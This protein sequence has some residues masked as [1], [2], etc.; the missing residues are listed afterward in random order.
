MSD[1]HLLEVRQSFKKLFC[2][3]DD[4][5]FR[6]ILFKS[7]FIEKSTVFT[8]FHDYVNGLIRPEAIVEFDK[9]FAGKVVKF[10]GEFSHDVDLIQNDFL[11]FFFVLLH[12]FDVDDFDCNPK[13]VNRVISFEYLSER[14]FAQTV[15]RVVFINFVC[16]LFK[17]HDFASLHR[18][19]KIKGKLINF[20]VL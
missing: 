16:A 1:T 5:R 9:I 11:H 14:S 19:I 13:I 4:L 18:M 12:H 3:F 2:Y 17:V 7:Q 15:L 10:F 8:K 6:I 20:Q